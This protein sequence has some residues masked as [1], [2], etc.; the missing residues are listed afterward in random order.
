MRIDR[1]GC[2]RP[3][4]K[5]DTE[6]AID[7]V[8]LRT[9]TIAEIQM[10]QPREFFGNGDGVRLTEPALDI[11]LVGPKI[12]QLESAKG[13]V[14]ENVD[15]EDLQIFARQIRQRDKSAHQWCR[16]GNAGRMSDR[17]E[18]FIR[19]AT[20]WT[21]NL[22]VRLAGQDVNAGGEGAIGAPVGNLDREINS[23]AER[24]AGH[25]QERE[26][27]MPR[28]VTQHVPAEETQILKN[29]LGAKSVRRRESRPL[30]LTKNE[31][32]KFHR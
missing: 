17:R 31:G 2:A 23:D 21:G 9:Q 22:Q 29:H 32:E 27:R 26:Q 10:V 18:S 25:V 16:S 30:M 5:A 19:Q 20:G 28:D 24:D 4:D 12:I 3:Q 11:E 15:A 6:F 13:G 14:G 1:G 8:H 7:S